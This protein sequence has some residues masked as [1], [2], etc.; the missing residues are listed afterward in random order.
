MSRILVFEIADKSFW[1]A[2]EE[3]TIQEAVRTPV[4]VSL[5]N[6]MQICQAFVQ[7]YVTDLVALGPGLQVTCAAAQNV[8]ENGDPATGEETK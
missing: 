8:K 2:G 4:I 1:S 7:I 3:K 5:Q 6:E